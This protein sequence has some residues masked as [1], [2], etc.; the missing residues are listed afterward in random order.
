MKIQLDD[1]G[2][3][4]INFNGRDASLLNNGCKYGTWKM[5]I[6]SKS[7]KYLITLNV[8]CAEGGVSTEVKKIYFT[9]HR[10]NK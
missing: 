6:P 8:E 3:I 10:K 5:D 1:E 2:K 4:R 7:N 9:R